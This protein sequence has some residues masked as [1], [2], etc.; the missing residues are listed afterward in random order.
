M[1]VGLVLP[2]SRASPGSMFVSQD[3]DDLLD[4]LCGC[5]MVA[6]LG[7]SDQVVTHFLLVS[8]LRCVLSAVRLQRKEGQTHDTFCKCIHRKHMH[9]CFK[10]MDFTVHT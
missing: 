10:G 2:C 4:E 3:V 8:F 7:G 1:S 9:K 6:V 5:H